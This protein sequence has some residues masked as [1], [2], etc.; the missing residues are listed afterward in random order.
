MNSGVYRLPFLYHHEMKRDRELASVHQEILDCRRCPL[1]ASRRN[2]VPGEGSIDARVMFVGEAPGVKE[3]ES[4][5]P[6][7]G[8]SGNL[9]TVMIAEI[10]LSRDE[11][12]ITSVL[13]S[14]PPGNRTPRKNE[15]E[16]CRPYLHRQIDIIRPRIVVLLGGVA[17][18]S[19][20]GPWKISEAHGRIH[21]A[22]GRRFFITYHPAAALRFPRLR[23]TMRQDFST[24]K[25]ELD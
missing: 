9:L 15:V 23:D 2:A 16:A 20:I 17:V 3:D 14:R 10:G 19:V 4:G 24:L 12:F 8:R 7:V 22:E 5:R 6:F 25:R 1:H 21:E 11:V 18:S 13:K